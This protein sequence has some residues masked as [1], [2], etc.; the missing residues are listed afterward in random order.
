MC[1]DHELP[2]LTA[3]QLSQLRPEQQARYHD[4]LTQWHGELKQ[5]P[6]TTLTPEKLVRLRHIARLMREL[7]EIWGID[8]EQTGNAERG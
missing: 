1:H 8:V 7:S 4:L 3:E 2:L 5:L 6:G